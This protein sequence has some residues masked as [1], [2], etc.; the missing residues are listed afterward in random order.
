MG[1]QMTGV[2]HVKQALDR[3]LRSILGGS[4]AV[5]RGFAR[6]LTDPNH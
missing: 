3:F 4:S 1:L 2:L 5:R 6:E